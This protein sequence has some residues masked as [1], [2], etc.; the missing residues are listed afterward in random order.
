ML[1]L[2]KNNKQN[3]VYFEVFQ[4]HWKQALLIFNKMLINDD[5]IEIIKNNLNQLMGLLR[6]ELNTAAHFYARREMLSNDND[7]TNDNNKNDE[8]YSNN[9]KIL[10]Y[11]LRNNIFS[12]F[13]SWTL[14]Y[15]E[16]LF[17]LKC[18]QLRH[19][20]LL[21]SQ[22]QENEH[23]D[24]LLCTQ[25]HRPLF[26]LLMHCAT[27]NSP[28][29]EKYAVEILN[30]LCVCICRNQNLL[31]I[32]F[33][34]SKKIEFI[35]TTETSIFSQYI[36]DTIKQPTINHN[37]KHMLLQNDG[38]EDQQ[39]SKFIIFSLLIPYIHKEGSLG[40]TARNALLMIMQLS[41]RNSNLAGFIVDN[42]DFC[43]IL[44]TG[45]SG[46]YS[47]LPQKSS[48]NEAI[49]FNEIKYLDRNDIT[50]TLPLSRFINSLEF[51]NNVIHVS[52]IQIQIQLLQYVYYGFLLPVV[53]PAL[54]Q[55]KLK[56]Y[57]GSRRKIEL[58]KIFILG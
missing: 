37:F 48:M 16:Y 22:L 11:T 13:Y 6:I 33:E 10:E 26:A 31:N 52:H 24:L 51:C 38:F 15:P 14:S 43:P 3:N 1:K 34:R 19:Y 56:G 39:P 9:N 41:S 2:D 49:D 55:V 5:D 46:L 47:D 25:L 50:S 35:P 7:N 32:F 30:Q 57:F 27:H 20:E 29:I 8:D 12:I 45:L 18:E 23:T 44:A 28:E 21:I 54:T 42:T 17:Q 58:L 4:D 36:Q 40:Q 53:L